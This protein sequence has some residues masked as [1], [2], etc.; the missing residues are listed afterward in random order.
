MNIN[1]IFLSH[2]LNE[3]HF[4]Y[5]NRDRIHISNPNS[6]IDGDTSNNTHLSLPTH[7]GTHIDYPYHFDSNYKNGD[8]FPP[9]YF[10]SIKVQIID[11]SNS[12]NAGYYFET[13][14]FDGIKFISDT[15]ILIIKTGMGD[16]LHEDIYWNDNPGFSPELAAYF[17]QKM[18]K[19]RLFGFDSIS[20]TGRRFRTEGKEAHR[21]FL[22]EQNI[23][24]LEDMYLEP[25]SKNTNIEE[26][27]I[28]P[29]RFENADGAPV[30]VFAKICE[31]SI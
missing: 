17:K 11:K 25:L 19:L 24:I 8:N 4:S 22:L 6:I 1:W 10:I 12:N 26:V 30:T 13:K 27:I 23:L 2:Q 9:E 14:D 7:F 20:L 31:S 5:G 28:S 29:L 21:E 15:E 18:P 3:K 16:H